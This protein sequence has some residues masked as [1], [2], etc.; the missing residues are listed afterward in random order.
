ME[1]VFILNTA[2]VDDADTVKVT[3]W[4]RSGSV[5]ETRLEV[6]RAYYV[7]TDK[8][9]YEVRAIVANKLVADTPVGSDE[10]LAD[11][12]VGCNT[13]LQDPGWIEV[14]YKGA[15]DLVAFNCDTGHFDKV[16]ELSG[17]ASTRLW[18]LRD[19]GASRWR[20]SHEQPA[21]FKSIIALATHSNQAALTTIDVDSRERH[22]VVITA[23]EAQCRIDVARQLA[24]VIIVSHQPATLAAVARPAVVCIDIFNALFNL[25]V[26]KEHTKSVFQLCCLANAGTDGDD[27][28]AVLA[29]PTSERALQI[30]TTTV[31]DLFLKHNVLEAALEMSH[32]T[33]TPIARLFRTRRRMTHVNTMMLALAIKHKCVPELAEFTA[34]VVGGGRSREASRGVHDGAFA[35]LD[36][37]S[38]Y[39]SQIIEHKL[40]WHNPPLT[41]QLM[42]ELRTARQEAAAAGKP[43][44]QAAL[45]LLANSVYGCLCT[46]TSI[47]SRFVLDDTTSV[48]VRCA[49]HGRAALGRVI[50]LAAE[51]NIDVLMDITDSVLVRADRA[52]AIELSAAA[53]TDHLRLQ[54]KEVYD[55]VVVINKNTYIGVGFDA[56]QERNTVLQ[57]KGVVLWTDCTWLARHL[58]DALANDTDIEQAVV[59]AR[60]ELIANRIAHDWCARELVRFAEGDRTGA[61]LI[62]NAPAGQALR[63][64][65]VISDNDIEWYVA[66]LQQRLRKRRSDIRAAAPSTD[67]A[68]EAAVVAEAAA[69]GIV[70]GRTGRVRQGA[71]PAAPAVR[72]PEPERLIDIEDLRNAGLL[73]LCIRQHIDT[74]YPHE[75]DDQLRFYRALRGLGVSYGIT[76][77]FMLSNT[78]PDKHRERVNKLRS[79]EKFASKAYQFSHDSIVAKDSASCSAKCN[80]LIGDGHC[81]YTADI[82]SLTQLLT[83]TPG[84]DA[85]AIERIAEQ[86][87]GPK[88]ACALELS[89]RLHRNLVISPPEHSRDYVK[90]ALAARELA[91]RA[92]RKAEPQTTATSKSAARGNADDNDDVADN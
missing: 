49:A 84:L 24:P 67:E 47:G 62:G 6:E 45:K 8:N 39:T 4:S 43:G 58:L 15:L 5:S 32:R 69:S 71:I 85:N 23:N 18:L 50:Q 20:D 16:I 22:T 78:L 83:S 38:A 44:V 10:L 36:F 90:A 7:K 76:E 77:R 1:D 19:I 63:G 41:P 82:E 53:S 40:C 55:R 46:K 68:T 21:P 3:H 17:D 87:N 74:R 80:T 51:R 9:A 66:L 42:S 11:T 54:L 92:K 2:N 48:G 79:F 52:A 91:S 25:S 73:P 72:M 13:D 86:R 31:A 70:T 60:T 12:P 88:V 37:A 33:G 59:Q 65:P 57:H 56:A 29:D 14:R 30:A 64:T 89:T 75:H 26:I 35:L 28:T 27:L 61:P 81:P 34:T